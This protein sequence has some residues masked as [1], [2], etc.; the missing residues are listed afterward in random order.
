MPTLGRSVAAALTSGQAAGNDH[1]RSRDLLHLVRHEGAEV[2]RGQDFDGRVERHVEPFL[3]LV[4]FGLVALGDLGLGELLALR[5]RVLAGDAFFALLFESFG[6][7]VSPELVEARVV[8]RNVFRTGCEHRAQRGLELLA[9]G[10]VDRVR[11]PNGVDHLRG[12]HE[13]LA[14][15]QQPTEIDDVALQ[16]RVPR[17]TRHSSASGDPLGSVS[18]SAANERASG[19]L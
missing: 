11:G 12:C 10:D 7:A 5:L 18:P 9:I 3:V 2:A 13:H 4:G 16:V 19:R 14:V 15:A 6:H 17:L 1:D 8:D